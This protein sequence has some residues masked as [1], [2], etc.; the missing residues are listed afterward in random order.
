MVVVTYLGRGEWAAIEQVT[1]GPCGLFT[2]RAALA[3]AGA[4]Q[5]RVT[6]VETLDLLLDPSVA[7][8]VSV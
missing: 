8:T 7:T 4:L 2:R 6:L 3:S 1:V 5:R